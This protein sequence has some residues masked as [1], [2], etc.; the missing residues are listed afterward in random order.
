[1]A[2]SATFAH[3]VPT[4]AG[5]LIKDELGL[6]LFGIETDAGTTAPPGGPSGGPRQ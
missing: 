1:V 4:S 3:P 2:E 5:L 6:A